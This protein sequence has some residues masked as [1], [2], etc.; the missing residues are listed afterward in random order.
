MLV[1]RWHRAPRDDGE[2]QHPSCPAGQR[3]SRAESRPG[4]SPPASIRHRKRRRMDRHRK[5]PTAAAP[6]ECVLKN[7]I[8]LPT[9]RFQLGNVTG[10][11]EGEEPQTSPPPCRFGDRLA[12]R[13]GSPK[14]E[15]GSSW[16][17]LVLG[18]Q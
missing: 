16:L 9:L 1:E 14:G 8:S 11:G 2:R 12:K 6:V 5:T 10:P 18:D 17:A 4:G 7:K 13:M 3:L 15:G